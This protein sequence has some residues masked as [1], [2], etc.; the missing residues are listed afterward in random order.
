M[1]G[2]LTTHLIVDEIDKV[3]TNVRNGMANNINSIK[4][5]CNRMEDVCCQ[6]FQ[7]GEVSDNAIFIGQVPKPCVA[8]ERH[9]E[10]RRCRVC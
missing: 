8:T 4:K 1:I 5:E 10:V 6:L 2:S 7:I 3:L 9:V